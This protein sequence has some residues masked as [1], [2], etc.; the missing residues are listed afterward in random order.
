[1][2]AVWLKKF[3]HTEHEKFHRVFRKNNRLMSESEISERLKL[4]SGGQEQLI[5]DFP[6]EEA[7]DNLI[8]EV[9]VCGGEA[10]I[11]KESDGGSAT[12]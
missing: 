6:V 7:A 11:K 12:A 2:Y 5:R 10:E 9:T 4:V 8:K 3:P 1:M